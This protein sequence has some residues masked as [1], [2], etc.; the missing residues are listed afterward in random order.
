MGDT[1][2]ELVMQTINRLIDDMDGRHIRP[3]HIRPER[4]ANEL[5]VPLE[6]IRIALRTLYKEGKTKAV[7]GINHIYITIPHKS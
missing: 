4:I 6:S 3:L 5:Q 7:Q 2:T 1:D